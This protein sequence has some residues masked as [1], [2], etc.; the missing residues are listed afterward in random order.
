MAFDESKHARGT[1]AQGGQFVSKGGQ[2]TSDIG[3]DGKR[4]SGYGAAGGDDNVKA[5][6][7]ELNRLGIGDAAGAK[8]AV[9]GKFGPK[10]TAAVRRLQRRLGLKV[11]GRVTPALLKRLKGV[12]KGSKGLYD[13][14]SG[15]TLAKR[16]VDAKAR[17]DAAARTA[18]DNGARFDKKTVH[19]AQEGSA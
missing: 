15:K 11:D 10:T 9:D 14:K 6:Q 17:K 18:R 1:G 19:R 13:N 7:R 2:K 4:G 5:L 12:K 3:Y 16:K 8:L